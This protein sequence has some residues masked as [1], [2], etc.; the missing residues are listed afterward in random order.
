MSGGGDDVG[1][2]MTY[3]APVQNV[4]LAHFANHIHSILI[5]S[6]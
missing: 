3:H 5:T 2:T 4:A 1:E 6:K